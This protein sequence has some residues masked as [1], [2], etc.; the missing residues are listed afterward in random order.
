M[1]NSL[2]KSFIRLTTNLNPISSALNLP[3]SRPEARSAV[4]EGPAS[5]GAPAAR[6][7]SPENA[8]TLSAPAFC[9]AEAPSAEA[10]LSTP[11]HLKLTPSSLRENRPALESRKARRTLFGRNA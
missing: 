8:T 1:T 5:T 3:S 4:V 11:P 10:S 2:T 9:H 6:R 7:L